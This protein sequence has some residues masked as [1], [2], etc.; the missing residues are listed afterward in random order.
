MITATGTQ[1]GA[2]IGTG[3]GGKCGNITI[4][5]KQGDTKEKFLGRMKGHTGVGAGYNG[6]C[7]TVTWR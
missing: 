7:G 1:Y 5:L 2:G 3:K 6:N 4:T